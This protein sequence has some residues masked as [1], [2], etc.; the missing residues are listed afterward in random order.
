MR[1]IPTAVQN[2]PL[3]ADD[4]LCCA[5]ISASRIT[6]CR[7]MDAL[8]LLRDLSATAFVSGDTL[9]QK[10]GISRATV[11]NTLADVSRYGISLYR[12]R[13]K[14]YR[15]AHPIEWLDEA[16][17]NQSLTTIGW[18]GSVQVLPVTDSTNVQLSR[19]ALHQPQH[20]LIVTCEWQ[21]AGK[22]RMGRHW[23]APLGGSLLFSVLWQFQRSLTELAG[24]SLV[25]GHALAEALN[26][27]GYPVQLKWPNDLVCPEGKLGGILI[28]AHGESHG[29]SQV[30]IGIG[31]NLQLHDMVS[32]IEQPACDLARIGPPPTRQKLLVDLLQELHL[33]LDTFNQQGFAPFATPW[34]NRHALHNQK[35]TLLRPDGQALHGIVTG[36]SKDGALLFADEH[37]QLHTLYSGDVS[38][39]KVNV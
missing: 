35:A 25:V 36:I 24:L 15:L 21:E 7:L 18:P 14:G 13:G 37:Q 12:I 39:R 31:L 9:A 19:L 23:Q 32:Q 22:G 17:L 3:V 5:T 10:H 27:T 26:R 30:I 6:L 20:G 34:Q 38:L 33:H 4:P 28:E 1:G 11:S 16:A 2:L 29:P 8:P